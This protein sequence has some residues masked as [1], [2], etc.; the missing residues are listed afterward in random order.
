L[1]PEEPVRVAQSIR[2]LGLK[3]AVITSV[4]RDDL[5]DA[6]AG[7]WIETLRQVKAYNPR[8][9]LE[10]LIPD[11]GGNT[12]SIA[13]V[14]ATAPEIISHNM[15]TVKR[16]TP[17][18]RSSARYE[19][20]LAVLKQVGESNVFA[21]TG[22]ML[23]LGETETEVLE[24]MEDVLSAGCYFLSI[25]QYLQPSRKHLPVKEYIHP[26]VFEK[27]R[28][29]ACLSGFL[30]VESGPLVRSSYRSAEYLVTSDG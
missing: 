28:E 22:L 5:P 7:H 27:Y 15:E 21:K 16:L 19:R 1:D 24:C 30:H 9:T 4:D 23:G 8:N 18:V 10:A 26:D 20:S 12:E 13:G 11:F 2:D 17:L 6:G 25:G 14:I 29:K 3:H